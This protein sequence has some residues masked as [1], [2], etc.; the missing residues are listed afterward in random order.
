M[1]SNHIWHMNIFLCNLCHL[2]KAC[3]CF[4]NHPM[5]KLPLP[6]ICMH[7]FQD[8]LLLNKTKTIQNMGRW[9]SVFIQKM[10]KQ[11]LPLSVF[12]CSNFSNWYIFQ[13]LATTKEGN[14]VKWLS[15]SFKLKPKAHSFH[16]SN[17]YNLQS[18][19][20]LICSNYCMQSSLYFPH[21]SS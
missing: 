6:L 8:P 11:R 9:N 5:W 18:T 1:W 15:F 16:D 14:T 2:E 19:S 17:L 21:I 7:L 13:Y 3:V 4:H 20:Q 10:E 12:A